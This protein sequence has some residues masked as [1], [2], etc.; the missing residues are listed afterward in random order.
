MLAGKIDWKEVASKLKDAGGSGNPRLMLA[1]QKRMA[2]MSVDELNVMFD[3][4]AAGGMAERERT[5]IESQLLMLLALERPGFVLE[6]FGDSSLGDDRSGK[7]WSLSIAFKQWAVE[8]AVAAGEWLDRQMAEGNFESKELKGDRNVL[9]Q[10]KANLVLS[11]LSTD[12][13]AAARRVLAMPEDERAEC[14]QQ[15]I[16]FHLKPGTEKAYA[17]LVRQ[18]LPGEKQASVLASVA[19]MLVSTGRSFEQV[20]QYAAV[21]GASDA[22]RGEIVKRAVPGM[23]V[24]RDALNFAGSLE[25][26]RGWAA[27]Q[28]PG[29]VNEITGTALGQ[30]AFRDSS[31]QALKLA[32]QYQENGG[33]DDVIVAFLNAGGGRTREQSTELLG[34]IAD[35]GRREEVRRMLES[36]FGAK[37]H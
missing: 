15:R 7:T 25:D 20:D 29:V 37:P 31:G 34:R 17:D 2:A 33:G 23:L 5:M 30:F 12:P 27:R 22:E 21:I 19:G 13:Q 24:S 8:D 14:L 32:I 36:K 4:I 9:R 18:S 3:K 16:G 6:R 11:L 1:L 35:E 10:F 26:A 28:A